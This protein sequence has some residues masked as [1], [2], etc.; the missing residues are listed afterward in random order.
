V[1]G[2]AR[3]LPARAPQPR[4]RPP[5]TVG[6]EHRSMPERTASVHPTSLFVASI[7]CDAAGLFE[8]RGDSLYS[9]NLTSALHLLLFFLPFLIQLGRWTEIRRQDCAGKH[10]P[11]E[12]GHCRSPS[13]SRELI[14]LIAQVGSGSERNDTAAEPHRNDKSQFA[15]VHLVTCERFSNRR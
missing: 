2:R 11:Q 8:D 12:D 15:A 7:A 4:L 5:A 9:S 3:C 6:D 14:T 1:R 10:N 13:A